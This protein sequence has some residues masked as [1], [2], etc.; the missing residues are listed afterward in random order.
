MNLGF[1]YHVPVNSTSH[2]LFIPSYFGVFIDSIASDVTNLLLFMHEAS[3]TD[4]KTCDYKIRG[5]NVRFVSMGVKTRSY[6]R[7]LFPNRILKKIDGEII[8]CDQLLIRGP[9]PLAPNFFFRYGK[10][11]QVNYMLVGDYKEGAKHLQQPWW[12]LIPIKF[13]LYR[14]DKQ[15][16][17]VI[18]KNLVIVNSST[19]F[20]EY[21]NI[22]KEIYEIKTSTLSTNDFFVRDNTCLNSE[23]HLLYTGRIDFAKGL[24]EL[25]DATFLLNKEGR[26]ITTHI[27]GWEDDSKKPVENTL[28]EFTYNLNISDKVIFHGKKNLG[29]ELNEMYRMADIYIIPSYH[30]GFPRTIWEAMANCLPVIATNV[31][32]IKS[33]TFGAC[34]IIDPKSSLAIKNSVNRLINEPHLRKQMI[35]EGYKLARQNTLENSAKSIITLLKK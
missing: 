5:S 9:S 30:E 7:Y 14:N 27:V 21:K 17:N 32:S 19:L 8:K 33:Y 20:K 28:K 26:C 35:K 4:V 24:R 11:I 34:E 10:Q 3:P 31:G 12:R 18:K 29:V 23:I 15:L 2:G 1:Y 25:I 13:F 22:S 16:R 6:D